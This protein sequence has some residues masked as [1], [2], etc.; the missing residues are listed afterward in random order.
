MRVRM[1]TLMAGPGGVFSPGELADLPQA[2]AYALCEG[3]YAEQVDEP[4][5]MS[6]AAA[7]HIETATLA[8]PE[9]AVAPRQRK[10]R[11]RA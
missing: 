1:K 3:G 5:G 6:S 8:P 4:L 7:R 11:S 9:Q 10:A 2:T